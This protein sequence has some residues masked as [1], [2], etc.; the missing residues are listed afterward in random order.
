MDSYDDLDTLGKRVKARRL[1][2][3]LSQ[4]QL[5]GLADM[6]Q[7]D[8]SKIERGDSQQ[9]SKIA[10]L[11]AALQCNAYWLATGNGDSGFVQP[12]FSVE[13]T[14]AQFLPGFEQLSIT[15]LSTGAS[16]GPG[17]EQ[18]DDVVIGRITVRPEWV[19]KTLKP[20][21]KIENLRFIHGYGDSME[22]TFTD[23]DILLVDT[24]VHTA[25]IDGIYVLEA[26]DRLFIKRVTERF[27]GTHEITSDNPRVK[28]VQALDGSQQVDILGRVVWAWN[29]KKL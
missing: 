2:L 19:T 21:T 12:A 4:T 20:L 7:G 3:K 22:P 6:S 5:A 28:T 25:D 18:H 23:G 26:N 8:I 29:G 14:K 27:D 24:G 11:A 9:T 1:Y 13:Q 16:M 15:V 17:A 10:Q